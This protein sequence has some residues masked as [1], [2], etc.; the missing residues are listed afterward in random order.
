VRDGGLAPATG[1]IT[2]SPALNAIQS[3]TNY[4]L[5]KVCHP[6]VAERALSRV[7]RLLRREVLIPVSVLPDGGFE[8]GTS[9]WTVVATAT[10]TPEATRVMHGAGSMRVQGNAAAP[11]VQTV[12]SVEDSTL[13]A[14]VAGQQW[15][16]AAIARSYSG[17]MTLVAY[18]GNAAAEI[19]TATTGQGR[20]MELLVNGGTFTVPTGCKLIRVRIR[21]TIS[22]DDFYIDD[23]ILWPT[24]RAWFPLP[25]FIE[26]PNDVVD[27]GY[28]DRPMPGPDTNSYYAD[29]GQWYTWPHTVKPNY[30]DEGGV[31]ALSIELRTP[32]IRPLYV[33]ARRPFADLTT[34]TATTTADR[35]LVVALTLR[36]VYK[37]LR[38]EARRRKDA[39]AERGW[40]EAIGEVNGNEAVLAF[41]SRFGEQ[42]MIVSVPKRRSARL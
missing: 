3:A 22:T 35:D 28:F 18:D 21:G 16:L 11:T 4:S 39:D 1:V 29:Q 20:W 37:T 19:A 24:Q 14:A 42:R 6:Q 8:I 38:T 31:K 9:D 30:I 12:V 10:I 33:R 7:L 34:D 27:V 40:D 15:I 32:V 41:D 5:W 13:V 26:D 25:S 36:E 17:T 2:F 23:V